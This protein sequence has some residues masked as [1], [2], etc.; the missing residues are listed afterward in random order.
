MS[1]PL[2]STDDPVG[3]APHP[4]PTPFGRVGGPRLSP[5]I[6]D[7]LRRG[8]IRNRYA[9]HPMPVACAVIA[10]AARAGHDLEHLRALLADERNMGGEWY[11]RRVDRDGQHHADRQLTRLFEGSI[12]RLR[13]A[14]ADATEARLAAWA[15][16]HAALGR[17]WPGRSGLTRLKVYLAHTGVALKAGSL[18]YTASTRQLAE[19]A[20]VFRTVAQ[21]R[22]SE[23]C[24]AGLIRVVEPARG[25][26]PTRWRLVEVECAQP[27]PVGP[28][29]GRSITGSCLHPAF[30]YGTGLDGR[31]WYT[32]DAEEP[33][34]V[35][36]LSALV[37]LTPETLRRKLRNLRHA[38]LAEPVDGGGWRR[39]DPPGLLHDIATRTGMHERATRQRERHR[40]E[41]EDHC[42]QMLRR[43][44]AEGRS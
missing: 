25:T 18:T 21:S 5:R 1:A 2:T 29:F 30:R 43:A 20:E 31:L 34:T 6:F 37:R 10:E 23:L 17:S 44:E 19:F 28:S 9:G 42:R 27:D 22:N 15:L 24:D 4:N 40:A 39:C 32:L 3:P 33:T 14:L 12:A 7:L 13:P 38:G 41:R 36:E 11:Q 16:Q 35:A 8:D 26:R